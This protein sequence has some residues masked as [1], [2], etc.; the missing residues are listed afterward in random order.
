MLESPAE[1]GQLFT[2]AKNGKISTLREMLLAG[3]N[4]D[5][6]ERDKEGNS[7]VAVAVQCG[8]KAVVEYLVN[9]MRA[10][11]NT[12]NHVNKYKHDKNFCV[13]CASLCFSL[14][15]HHLTLLYSTAL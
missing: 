6:N 8:S 3:T 1:R 10:E 12:K 5:F 11:V 9:E 4:V 13:Y 15:Y 14:S 7:A 2:A